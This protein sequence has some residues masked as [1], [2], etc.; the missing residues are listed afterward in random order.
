MT[1]RRP[2]RSFQKYTALSVRSKRTFDAGRQVVGEAKS[3]KIPVS[4]AIQELRPYGVRT[5]LRSVEKYWGEALGRDKRGRIVVARGDRNVAIMRALTTDGPRDVIVAGSR[6]RS[7]V[8]QHKAVVN[9]YRAGRGQGPLSEWKD[10]Y[11]DKVFRGTDG[12]LYVLE[13]DPDG[14]DHWE[15]M[16]PEPPYVEVV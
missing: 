4:Q 11:G 12:H 3:R 16:P 9:H 5:S 13:T 6:N 15:P 10:R 1:V 14:I 7:V 2:I 8:G